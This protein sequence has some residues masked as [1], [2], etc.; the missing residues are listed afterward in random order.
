MIFLLGIS[1]SREF[2][3]QPILNPVNLM[4]TNKFEMMTPQVKITVDPDYTNMIMTDTVNGRTC[5]IIPVDEGVM[6]NGIEIS[7]GNSAQTGNESDG[8]NR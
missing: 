1:C 3:D 5:L 8:N 7:T 6:V 2:G 4:E